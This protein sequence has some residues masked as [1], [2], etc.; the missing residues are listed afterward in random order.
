M[1]YFVTWETVLFC[2]LPSMKKRRDIT[3]LGHGNVY[4]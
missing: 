2:Q 4:V 3:D 1:F